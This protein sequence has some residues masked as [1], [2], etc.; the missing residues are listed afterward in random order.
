MHSI[1]HWVKRRYDYMMAE[2]LYKEQV[3]S[4]ST[5]NLEPLNPV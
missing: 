5:L 1:S 2:A 4:L 3:A